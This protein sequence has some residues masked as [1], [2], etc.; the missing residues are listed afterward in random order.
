MTN[1]Q[2]FSLLKTANTIQ[3]LRFIFDDIKVG[4]VQ[5][6]FNPKGNTAGNPLQMFLAGYHQAERLDNPDYRLYEKV[7][8]HYLRLTVL[9]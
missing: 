7:C 9:V 1:T 2:L 6:A 4:S 8:L 3:E 5:F